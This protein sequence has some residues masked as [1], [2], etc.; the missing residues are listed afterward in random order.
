MRNQWQE[1]RDAVASAVASFPASFK[2]K[3]FPDKTF[4]V[5]PYSSY[6]NDNG[7]IMLYTEVQ[8]DYG[9]GWESFAKGTAE[10][11]RAQIVGIVSAPDLPSL[12][13]RRDSDH[14]GISGYFHVTRITP[15]L[16]N[17]LQSKVETTIR[18]WLLREQL[19]TPNEWLTIGLS[20]G[21]L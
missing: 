8:V 4:R 21:V 9:S 1:D 14:V 18:E 16:C 3:A 19:I 5:S 12:K 6:V 11:L 2:L 7:V 13:P 17:A 20:I 10:E 15:E